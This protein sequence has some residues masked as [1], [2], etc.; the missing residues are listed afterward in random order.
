MPEE[1]RTRQAPEESEPDVEQHDA[2]EDLEVSKE[3]ADR[4]SGGAVAG[5]TR[6]PTGGSDL[7]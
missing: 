3:E 5:A 2:Q 7:V 6:D 1:P 4:L